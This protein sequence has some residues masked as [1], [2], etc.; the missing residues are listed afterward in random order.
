MPLVGGLYP[1]CRVSPSDD[2]PDPISF[3]DQC[4]I[5]SH[6]GRDVPMHLRN[7]SAQPAKWSRHSSS[8]IRQCHT[9][10]YTSCLLIPTTTASSRTSCPA[11]SNER[12]RNTKIAGKNEVTKRIFNPASVNQE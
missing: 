7:A 5:H 4:R 2:D 8:T 10:I 9:C 1:R 6:R 11:L 12:I 3:W